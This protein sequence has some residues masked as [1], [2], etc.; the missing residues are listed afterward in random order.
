MLADPYGAVAF[1]AAYAAAAVE[2]AGWDEIRDV[3]LQ[4]SDVAVDLLT[5]SG[6]PFQELEQLAHRVRADVVVIG[7]TTSH[8]RRLLGRSIPRRFVQ[9]QRWPVIVVP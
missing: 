6:D 4:P 1:A 8:A 9:A 7:A 3:L 2:P 5:P